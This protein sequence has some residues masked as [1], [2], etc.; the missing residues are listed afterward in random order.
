MRSRANIL[1]TNV[2]PVSRGFHEIRVHILMGV[3]ASKL[4]SLSTFG[5]PQQFSGKHSIRVSAVFTYVEICA[6]VLVF[7]EC[8]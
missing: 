7:G 4:R 5:I 8:V 2:H 1:Q 3:T 6:F